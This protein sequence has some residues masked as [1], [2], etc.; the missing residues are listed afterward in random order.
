MRR[1]C[2]TA[3]ILRCMA[4]RAVAL[5]ADA[6]LRGRLAAAAAATVVAFD[7]SAYADGTRRLFAAQN[8]LLK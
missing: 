4:T 3:P 6:E 1:G 2:S 8:R 7:D 5:L